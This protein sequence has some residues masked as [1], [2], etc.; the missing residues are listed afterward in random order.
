MDKAPGT[1]AARYGIRC[2]ALVAL[3]ALL[4][5]GPASW[6][7]WALSALSPH[8]GVISAVALRSVGL[9]TA[10]SGPM[11]AL[12]ILRRRWFCR[13]LC[14]VGLIVETCSRAGLLRT[15]NGATLPPIGQWL[16]L[17][18][19]GG[20]LLGCPLFLWLDPLAIFSGAAGVLRAPLTVAS[21][22][23]AAGLAFIVVLSLVVPNLWCMRLCPLGGTQEMLADL[24]RLLARP[25]RS[26]GS[27]PE[28]G[29]H[30]GRRSV[31]CAGAGA[32][33]A[34]AIPKFFRAS[35]PVLRPPGALD[36]MHF[37]ALCVRCGNCVRAC[38]SRIIERQLTGDVSGFL[39]P[40]VRF[41]TERNSQR[42][43]LETCHEC[44]RSCPAGAI[45][46]LSLESK[47]RRPI[48]L[49]VIDMPACLIATD[50]TCAVCVDVCPQEAISLLFHEETYTNTVE[51]DPRRCNGCGACLLVCP[52]EVIA[53]QCV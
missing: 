33:W 34:L 46:R 23:P 25:V 19:L 22:A 15:F 20:A 7:P 32:A 36:E 14:P 37:K 16:A 8:V 41:P 43:C 51:V 6:G 17:V 3:T 44:T 39:T 49:A 26:E 45:E 28:A 13:H 18:S 10:C 1:R 5:A 35:P 48:G 31:L 40:V 11:I 21:A 30:L 29:P 50:Q 53:V 47:N 4:A 52:V 24:K 38:P 9:M 2:T 12:M 42:Y 27:H